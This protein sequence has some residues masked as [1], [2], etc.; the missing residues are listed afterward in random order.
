MQTWNQFWDAIV[1]RIE[2]SKPIIRC[3]K[4]RKRS[5]ALNI[6]VAGSDRACRP[7][8]PL[9]QAQTSQRLKHL[10][11]LALN[12]CP[13]GS[14]NTIRHITFIAVVC[15][16]VLGIPSTCS[17]K[18]TGFQG[19]IH[20]KTHTPP[21]SPSWWCASV[22]QLPPPFAHSHDY[23]E[24]FTS[25][26]SKRIIL[27]TICGGNIPT[28]LRLLISRNLKFQTGT[29]HFALILSASVWLR[30]VHGDHGPGGPNEGFRLFA[31]WQTRLR[32]GSVFT[33]PVLQCSTAVSVA[34]LRFQ[35]TLVGRLWEKWSYFFTSAKWMGLVEWRVWNLA[36][37]VALLNWN[38]NYIS[39][40]T[41]GII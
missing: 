30:G 23:V 25:L 24:H 19:S 29:F 31:R 26:T 7:L 14:I 27:L 10:Y 36:V 33:I 32:V 15:W 2:N 9:P 13:L 34:T 5:S 6:Y 17:G 28:S 4:K 12:L 1:V 38:G 40:H 21:S 37:N 11:C 3:T 39:F 35:C 16:G 20:K 41:T 8:C 22:H 18:S